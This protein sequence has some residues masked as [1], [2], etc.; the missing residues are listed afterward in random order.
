MITL[1][2]LWNNV[3]YQEKIIELM[4]EN[5]NNLKVKNYHHE[6]TLLRYEINRL[7]SHNEQMLK[8]ISNNQ[9]D[10]LQLDYSESYPN[11]PHNRPQ[12]SIIVHHEDSD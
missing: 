12:E 5:E 8:L 6:N 10:S 11:P 2:E 7:S 3:K 9:E 1:D 4:K